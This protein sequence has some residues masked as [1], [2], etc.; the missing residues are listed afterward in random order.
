MHIYYFFRP[1]R[2]FV[3]LCYVNTTHYEN[4]NIFPHTG[5]VLTLSQYELAPHI[6][7]LTEQ[8]TL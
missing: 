3:I 6:M 7:T 5:G 1:L 2:E 8:L 4:F